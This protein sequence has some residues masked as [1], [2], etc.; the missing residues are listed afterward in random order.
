MRMVIFLSVF[1]A[2]YGSLHFLAFW[3][4]RRAFRFHKGVGA[5]LGL[6]MGGMVV[7]PIMVRVVERQ[8]MESLARGLAYIGYTW[9]GFLFLF[10]GAALFLDIY[11]GVVFLVSL[12]TG[13]RSIKGELSPK[14]VF[15]L[16]LGAAFVLGI[17]AQI[18]AISIQ[19]EH[20]VIETPKIPREIGRFRIVQISDVHLGLMVGERRLA[21][22]MDAVRAENPDILVS[23]GDLLDGQ[24]DGIEGLAKAFQK[25]EPPY[26]KY[27]VNGNHE[28]YVGIERTGDFC[29]A[30]GFTLLSHETFDI[31]GV[32][33]IVGVDDPAASRFGLSGKVTEEQLLSDLPKERFVLLLKHRPLVD[34]ESKGLFDLQLSG[35]THGGQIFPFTLIIKM[36]YPIDS[37][38]LRLADGAL[39][40]VNRGAGTW[41]PPMRFLA[42]PEVTVIDLVHEKEKKVQLRS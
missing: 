7:C 24:I 29:K 22:I 41:G 33:V 17:Y 2:L 19:T 30:A 1:L 4:A 9:M 40:Y 3:T 8:G 28:Y 13:R 15:F 21:R 31:P 5:A 14:A 25:I 34:P 35:H 32:A 20:I 6:F 11:R 10:V 27:A 16:C 36:L 39:L 23:T 18:E 37:G 38:L 26:G 42:P 12:A